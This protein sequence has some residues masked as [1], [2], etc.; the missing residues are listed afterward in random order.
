M[1]TTKKSIPHRISRHGELEL[2]ELFDGEFMLDCK[3][4][5]CFALLHPPL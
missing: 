5:I 1:V 3:V 2:G 4:D